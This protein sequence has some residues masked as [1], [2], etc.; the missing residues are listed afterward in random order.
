MIEE[1]K[2]L[3]VKEIAERL[4]VTE[5]TIYNWID[6]GK[7]KYSKIGDV[8]RIPASEIPQAGY[9]QDK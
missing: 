4:R 7:I 5:K 6:T 8:I 1:D 3:T 9:K 2:L